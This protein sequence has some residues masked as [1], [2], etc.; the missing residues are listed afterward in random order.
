MTKR[1]LPIRATRGQLPSYLREPPSPVKKER[2]VS[3]Q[4]LLEVRRKETENR[5]RLQ[6]VTNLRKYPFA[7]VVHYFFDLDTFP[8]AKGHISYAVD[9]HNAL[10]NTY[11]RDCTPL[12]SG[13]YGLVLNRQLFGLPHTPH[14]ELAVRK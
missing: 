3:E 11:S 8:R 9:S 1:T 7:R 5:L 12:G 13:T 4:E 6:Q 10:N 14:P 2:V